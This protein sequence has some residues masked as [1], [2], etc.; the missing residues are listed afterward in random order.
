MVETDAPYLKPRNLRPRV[1]THR[2]E[3]RWLPWIVASLA[4]MREEQPDFVAEQTS[5]NARTFFRLPEI[6][7]GVET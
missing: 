5:T 7:A 1:K 2:N 4:E 6:Q 3:P